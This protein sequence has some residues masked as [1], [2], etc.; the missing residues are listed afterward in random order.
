[1][2]IANNKRL[3]E[4]YIARKNAQRALEALV[5][6]EADAG[7]GR[8]HTAMSARILLDVLAARVQEDEA[9]LKDTL[10]VNHGAE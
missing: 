3:F 10:D 9:A 4:R 7:S 2:N 1:M 8:S 6:R 5:K